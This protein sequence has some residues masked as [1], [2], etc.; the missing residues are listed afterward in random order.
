MTLRFAE[1]GWDH[2]LVGAML[3]GATCGGV[4]HLPYEDQ[5]KGAWLVVCSTVKRPF[6]PSPYVNNPN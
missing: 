4:G 6:P 2:R 5:P 1:E 3:V